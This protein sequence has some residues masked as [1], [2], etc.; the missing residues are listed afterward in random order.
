MPLSSRAATA[1]L[2]GDLGGTKILLE[3]SSGDTQQVLHRALYRAADFRGFAEVLRAFLDDCSASGAPAASV[4][5]AC[6]GVAGP[7]TGRQVKITNLPWALDADALEN[8]FQIASLTLVNDFVAAVQGVGQLQPQ[9]L[10]RLQAGEP[11]PRG[12]RVVLGAG[13]GF[14]AAHAIWTEAGYQASA[15]ESGHIGF[16]PADELQAALW[17][18]IYLR[19]GRVSLEHV[20]SGPGLVRIYEHLR[21]KSRSAEAEDLRAALD[22]GGGPAAISAHALDGGD[23]LALAALDLF[24]SCYGAAAG[25]HALS[26]MAR[27]GVYIAGGIAAKILPRLA[28]GGFAAAFEAKGVHRALMASFPLHVVTDPQLPLIGARQLALRA[29]ADRTPAEGA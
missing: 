25:D 17:R 12:T 19:E 23:P 26:L 16:A 5:S 4:A 21:R 3:I 2:A 20:V 11:L 13:T 8:E 6:L 15:G 7:V 28:A 24:I 1:V 27:G 18:D 29:L 22:A 9:H 10:S 14:G